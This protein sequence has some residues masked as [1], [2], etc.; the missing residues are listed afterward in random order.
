MT[1]FPTEADNLEWL[2]FSN[3]QIGCIVKG[4]AQKNPIRSY[5]LEI[6]CGHLILLDA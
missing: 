6:F 1:L 3:V 2:K 5:L 4:K